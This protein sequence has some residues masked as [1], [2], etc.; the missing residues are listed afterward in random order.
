MD[1]VVVANVK[2]RGC[3]AVVP[4]VDQYE[5]PRLC[6]RCLSDMPTLGDLFAAGTGSPMPMR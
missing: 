3:S 5:L 6:P 4:V 2:C 1:P